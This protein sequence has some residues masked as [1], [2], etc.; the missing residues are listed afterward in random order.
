LIPTKCSFFF[1]LSFLLA[2]DSPDFRRIAWDWEGEGEG[3]GGMEKERKKKEERKE[4]IDRIEP[5]QKRCYIFCYIDV[6]RRGSILSIS[7]FLS[8]FFF[9][10]FFS[11][12][13]RAPCNEKVR[14]V[15][16]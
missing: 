12:P 6:Y 11:P 5:R 15:G 13:T 1:F 14:A 9:F 10:L 4:E 3:E 8:F 7:P 2:S 16:G